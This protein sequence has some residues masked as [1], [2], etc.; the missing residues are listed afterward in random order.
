MAVKS[1]QDFINIEQIRGGV[2]ILKN[3]ALRGILMVS[4][5]NFALKSE[6]EQRAVIGSFQSFLNSLDFT[7]QIVVQSRKTNITGYIDKIKELEKN[8]KNEMLKHQTAGYREFL[9]QFIKRESIYTKRFFLVVPYSAADSKKITSQLS[10]GKQKG[11]TLTE[12]GFKRY[13]TQLFQRMEF[14]ALGLRRCGLQSSP[15]TTSELM[16]LFWVIHHPREAE[17]GYYPEFPEEF[18]V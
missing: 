7:C 1:T 3:K 8:Q 12:E 6:E 5:I 16:E 13:R 17:Q 14:V 9:E 10:R 18:N 11:S 4:S 2:V 15:L